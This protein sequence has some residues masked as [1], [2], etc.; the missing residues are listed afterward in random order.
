MPTSAFG[1][2][3]VMVVN[4][5][6]VGSVDADFAHDQDTRLSTIGYMLS[7]ALADGA[8]SWKSKL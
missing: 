5:E 3:F 1:L 8:A 2:L 4:L 6:L 7:L